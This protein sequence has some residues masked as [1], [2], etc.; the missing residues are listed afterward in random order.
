M[1]GTREKFTYKECNFCNSLQISTIPDDIDRHYPS[2][3][4]AYNN[5]STSGFR[6]FVNQRTGAARNR[7]DLGLGSALGRLMNR[8]RGPVLYAGAEAQK[9]RQWFSGLPRG[10]DSRVLDIGCGAGTL[11]RQMRRAGF[12]HL[13]GIDPYLP[14]DTE[15]DGITLL[16]R[17]T[18]Q[19]DDLGPFDFIMM[20]HVFEHVSD[21]AA[22]L[23]DIAGV[24]AEGGRVLLRVPV[25][26]TNSARHYGP[27]W[28]QLDPPRHL[29]VPSELGLRIL[30]ARVGYRVEGVDYDST[31]FQFWA[32]EQ[33]SAGIPLFDDPRSAAV[34]GLK[35]A[36]TQSE[37]ASLAARA[38]ALN[39]ASDGDQAAFFLT[40]DPPVAR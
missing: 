29:F 11:L 14:A 4:Y 6:S 19:M 8:W 33:Y 1:F 23:G 24:L 35:R 3:Y 13:V 34:K 37:L 28:V 10:L 12:R 15:V 7:E 17:T 2:N 39:V 40:L 5:N 9:A 16:R 31:E 22:V 36:F 30:A 26:A 27:N 21:P 32:S 20:H 25:A 38:Q 18:D